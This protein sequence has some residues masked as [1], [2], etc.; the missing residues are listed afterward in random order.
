MKRRDLLRISLMATAFSGS[1]ASAAIPLRM[2]YFDKYWPFSRINDDG[3]MGGALIDSI[4]LVGKKCGLNFTHSGYPWP[5]AQIMVKGGQLDGF[6]TNRTQERLAYAQFCETPII[7]VSNGIYHRVDDLRPLKVRTVAD[8]RQFRQGTYRDHGFAKENLEYDRMQLENDQE[9]VLRLIAMNALDTFVENEYVP[10]AKVKELGLT[11]KIR[12]TPLPFI[13]GGGFRF[14]LRRDYPDADKI[15]A[16]MEAAIQS[17]AKSGELA[18][19]LKKY[20]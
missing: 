15:L 10:A 20:R 11:E 7:R 13:D 19:L 8:L 6:C 3:S 2:G 16:A 1:V 9:S 17:A 18:T 4:N 5:R 12:F 14:G